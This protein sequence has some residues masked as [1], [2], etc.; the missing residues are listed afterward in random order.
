VLA[1]CGIVAFNETLPL[2]GKDHETA[3]SLAKA[4][5]GIPLV[6]V[7]HSALDINMVFFELSGG[8]SPS[9]IASDPESICARLKS[10][11]ILVNPPDSGVWRLVTHREILPE[12]VEEIAA[13]F[14]SAL[15]G[16]ASR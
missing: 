13:A 5:S 4:L 16:A 1:A 3:R 7:D 9:E 14:K 12:S 10:R 8:S 11:G 15:A 6:R 2:L